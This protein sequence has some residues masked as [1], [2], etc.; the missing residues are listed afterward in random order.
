VQIV[1]CQMFFPFAVMVC[2]YI[3]KSQL[4]QCFLTQRPWDAFF[5]S[6]AAMVAFVS[7]F[8]ALKHFP[9]DL[10]TGI[11][12]LGPLVTF[13]AS[14]IFLKEKTTWVRI[15]GVC[16]LFMISLLAVYREAVSSLKCVAHSDIARFFALPLITII[17]YSAA[18]IFGKRLM[19][20]ASAREATF[21]LLGW[22]SLF[23][24][25]WALKNWVSPSWEQLMWLL[26]VGG[27]EGLGQWFLSRALGKAPLSILAPLS[28]WKFMLTTL[29]GMFF[30]GSPA[31]P[32]F[33]SCIFLMII[34]TT[35][36]LSAGPHV[37]Q[38]EHKKYPN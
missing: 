35:L 19:R 31:R 25:G 1:F 34:M 9:L 37:R 30:F 14:L 36:I 3:S 11:R 13:L 24:S 16:G 2:I 20:F 26:V 28:L 12:L 7:W 6:F 8:Y 18:S 29:L 17:A 27:L 4:F 10:L 38:E 33:W 5:R 22:N 23:L 32:I 15:L 21:S